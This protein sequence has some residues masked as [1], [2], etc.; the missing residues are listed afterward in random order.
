MVLKVRQTVATTKLL[1]DAR[2]AAELDEV[3]ACQH[4]VTDVWKP[5][6]TESM[7]TL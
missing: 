6:D 2:E 3:P 4:S 1:C 5:I 7:A